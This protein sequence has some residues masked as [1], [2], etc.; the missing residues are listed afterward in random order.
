MRY[1][2][3]YIQLF[4]YTFRFNLTPPLH[5]PVP[6]GALVPQFYGYYKPETP[7]KGKKYLSPILLLEDCGEQVNV[8]AL[9]IDDRYG[10]RLS[11]YAIDWSDSIRSRQEC[12]SLF[13]RFHAA[14]W[15]HQSVFARNV[16][17]QRGSLF[18]FPTFKKPEERRFRLIDFGRSKEME[19]A[20][21]CTMRVTGD[22][23]C[24][25]GTHS[26]AETTEKRRLDK[27][28]DEEMNE[29]LIAQRLFRLVNW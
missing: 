22:C 8:D 25:K 12:F 4:T 9:G 21:H 7:G 24:R 28:A 15:L 17:V 18:D 26:N 2:E 23:Q 6:V 19:S 20:R 3:I 16:L 27:D 5:D 10:V 14:G 11:H 13:L 1:I 29:R